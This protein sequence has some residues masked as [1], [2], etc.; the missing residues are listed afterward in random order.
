[1]RPG[2]RWEMVIP[3]VFALLFAVS[4]GLFGIGAVTAAPHAAA[5]FSSPS[6]Q[7]AQSTVSATKT[8][9]DWRSTSGP[10]HT[11]DVCGGITEVYITPI[12]VIS[13]LKK[14]T[15]QLSLTTV[16]VIINESSSAMRGHPAVLARKF[17]SHRCHL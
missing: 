15:R 8:N 16:L 11:C 9:P 3:A 14:A 10:N 2:D 6:S 17:A 7:I 12:T 4:F 5:D 1:M 13:A